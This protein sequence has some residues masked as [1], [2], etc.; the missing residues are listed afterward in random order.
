MAILS[1]SKIDRRADYRSMGNRAGGQ[2]RRGV[3]GGAYRW[4]VGCTSCPELSTSAHT[5]SSAVQSAAR[6][7]KKRGLR[8]FVAVATLAA[9]ANWSSTPGGSA[10]E[11]WVVRAWPGS[12]RSRQ[13]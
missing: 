1:A 5:M 10:S 11:G 7:F 6:L 13:L 8:V 12:Y 2:V 9:S 4:R 3:P